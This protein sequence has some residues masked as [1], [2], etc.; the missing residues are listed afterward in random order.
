MTARLILNGKKAAQPDVR[1]A[2]DELL[3]SGFRRPSFIHGTQDELM[4]TVFMWAAWLLASAIVPPWT[5][6]A[7]E[8]IHR[9]VAFGDSTTAPRQIEGK[10]LPV[11]ADLL[12][13]EQ[14]IEVMNAGVPGDTTAAARLRFEKDVLLQRPDLVIIQFGIN[15]AAVDV[16]KSPPATSAR[17][18]LDAY[19]ANLRFF[20]NE[21]QRHNARVILMTPN[22]LRWTSKLRES[23]G[24]SPYDPT[25]PDGFNVLLAGYAQAVRD[26]ARD[27]GVS[28]VD[29]Y[30]A[31]RDRAEREDVTVDDFLLDGMHPNARGHR[32]T[33]ELL[34]AIVSAAPQTFAR[35]AAGIEIDSRATDMPNQPLG[36]FVRLGDGRVLALDKANCLMSADEGTTWQ[37][38][39]VFLGPKQFEVSGERAI[40]R[41]REGVLIA[42]FMN[43]A[44]KK[45]TWN[46]S[47]GDAPGAVLPQYVMRSTDD[48]AT[49]EAPQKLHDD[50]T[51]AV[52]TMI[53]TRRGRVVFTSMK[54]RHDP[55]RHVILTYCS[56]DQGKTWSASNVIDLGGAG[57]HDGVSE[58]TI[59]E[60]LDGKLL[61]LMRTNW[62]RFWF[63]ESTDGAM[64]W[65]PL[66]PSP[67]AA[68]SAPGQL[69]RLASGRVVLAWN[70]PFPEGKDAWPPIGGDRKW[71][72]TPVSNFRAELSMAFSDDDCQTWSSPVVIARTDDQ[73]QWLAYPYL[74]EQ[75]PGEL[76][77]TTMQGGV[78]VRLRE[79]D[80]VG[81]TSAASRER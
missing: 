79:A 52:R 77:I 56:D 2:V 33:A 28:L 58:S 10:A 62:G 61:M 45:W 8:P 66:G 78:R 4:H 35:T 14:G 68:S 41:T 76:W 54:L 42:A 19:A 60:L 16:W 37:Q 43:M 15:D 9:V 12:T 71:S 20:V 21:A 38:T 81:T 5:A 70:R 27:T 24:R 17:V 39:V 25:D 63:A 23:Y 75:T 30:Q 73:Q 50:W 22:P 18:P 57:N 47:L 74:F 59:V 6:G 44:E 46:D 40:L 36:P 80:F 51:G 48:G 32:L 67:V 64:S 31:Y 11:Y 26:V 72:A 53:Q 29:A 34:A 69:L 3:S 1:E 7:A 13:S 65:K 49:W 55:C